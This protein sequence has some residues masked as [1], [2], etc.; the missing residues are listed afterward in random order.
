MLPS[1]QSLAAISTIRLSLKAAV[2]QRSMSLYNVVDYEIILV[3]KT[4][5][6]ALFF[7]LNALH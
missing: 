1:S 5:S 4:L 6:K 3:V 7:A 2:L